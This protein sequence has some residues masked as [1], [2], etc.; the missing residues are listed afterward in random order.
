MPYLD[1]G[2]ASVPGNRYGDMNQDYCVVQEFYAPGEIPPGHRQTYIAAVCDGHGVLGDKAACYAGKTLV[3]HIYTSGLRNRLLRDARPEAEKLMVAAF[4]KGHAAALSLYNDPPKSIRY[5]GLR[6]TMA[7]YTLASSDGICVYRNGSGPERL[8]EFGCTCTCAVVQGHTVC[9]ANVGDSAAVLG[10][11]TGAAYTARTLTLRHNGHNVEEARRIKAVQPGVVKIKDGTGEDGYMQVVSGPWQG[12]ELAVTRALGHKH[13]ADYGVL[14]QPHVVSLEA[15]RDDCCLVLASDGVWDVM[16]GPEVVNRVMEAAADG[17]KA[18][19]AAKMLVEA[20]VDL[21][22]NSPCG[23]ADN[24][25]A[26]VVY[27]PIHGSP[28]KSSTST[29]STTTSS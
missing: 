20:A 19:E 23:E 18:T 5:G 15:G 28:S 12:Y 13:M 11:D 4:E 9:L 2:C 25:S 3:R 27:F 1:I 29:T 22:I 10:T 16:D 17:K 8:L 26:I 6:K 14:P 7:T 21:G 24:T